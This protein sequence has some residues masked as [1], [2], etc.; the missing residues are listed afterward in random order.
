LPGYPT[1]TNFQKK[2]G[3]IGNHAKK[4][5]SGLPEVPALGTIAYLDSQRVKDRNAEEEDPSG[6]KTR[7]TG[8]TYKLKR[9]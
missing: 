4:E 3:N 5:D 7:R 1:G 8:T 2:K 9:G 6:K